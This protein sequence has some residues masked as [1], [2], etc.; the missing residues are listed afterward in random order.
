MMLG[1]H[2]GITKHLLGASIFDCHGHYVNPRF[3]VEGNVSVD[4]RAVAILSTPL[5]WVFFWILFSL[6]RKHREIAPSLAL[7]SCQHWVA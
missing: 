3:L 7:A 2:T 5:G 1:K 4:S 6:L